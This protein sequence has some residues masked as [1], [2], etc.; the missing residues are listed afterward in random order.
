MQVVFHR[1]PS[2]QVF[3][4]LTLGITYAISAMEFL[5]IIHWTYSLTTTS[6]SSLLKCSSEILDYYKILEV[7]YDA[8]EDAIRSNFIRLALVFLSDPVKR[9]EYDEK[10]VL[11][12]QDFNAISLFTQLCTDWI[13]VLSNVCGLGWFDRD[14]ALLKGDS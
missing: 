13:I 1:N 5:V 11:V 6:A 3:K 8:T 4:L 14:N 10:G 12:I 2:E 7:D 9:R